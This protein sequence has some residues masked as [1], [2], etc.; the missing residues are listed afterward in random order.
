[1]SFK[2]F[3]TKSYQNS[4]NIVY[5]KSDREVFYL[6]VNKDFVSKK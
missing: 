6:L 1:M 3:V 4:I 5:E 2:A